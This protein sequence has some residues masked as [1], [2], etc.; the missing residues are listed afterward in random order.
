MEGDLLVSGS[1]DK[2][3][4]IWNISQKS[5]AQLNESIKVTNL[6]DASTLE[7]LNSS[8][9]M[10]HKSTETYQASSPES[11]NHTSPKSSRH[12]SVL[13]VLHGHSGGVRSLD[14]TGPLLFTGDIYGKILCW[15]VE[16]Y[17]SL[18]FLHKKYLTHSLSGNC[19]S[20]LS[21]HNSGVLS[22]HQ[23]DLLSISMT[24]HQ[25]AFTGHTDPITCVKYSG[26]KL[27][28][29]TLSGKLLYYR[30]NAPKM[31]LDDTPTSV[32]YQNLRTW[33]GK[34]DSFL[35]D[36]EYMLVNTANRPKDSAVG[37]WALCVH[38]DAWRLMAGGSEG[39]CILWNHQS[40]RM[41][42][43]LR[44]SLI[45]SGDGPFNVV[46]DNAYGSKKGADSIDTKDPSAHSEGD[47]AITGV[48][49]DDHFIVAGSM[50]GII[51][52]WEANVRL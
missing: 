1:E 9:P 32:V 38:A 40:K 46:V 2:T 13:R 30:L 18:R 12:P 44:G 43:S 17:S 21:V 48:A 51:R 34:K 45:D 28:V 11:K 7:T 33:A 27:I 41:L 29:S 5:L 25:R 8:R 26:E 42:Y 22:V 16:R 31:E 37:S 23:P 15:H 24:P 52:V 35:L 6:V 39:R 19:V 50:D 3:V 20:I 36:H 10:S 14:F 47:R 4:R 49:F